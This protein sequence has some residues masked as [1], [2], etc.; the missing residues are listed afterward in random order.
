METVLWIG[1]VIS[2]FL[3]VFTLFIINYKNKDKK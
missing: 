2:C 3:A 1:G